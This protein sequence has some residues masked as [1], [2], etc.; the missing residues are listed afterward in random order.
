VKE[1]K[2]LVAEALGPMVAA[3]RKA[4]PTKK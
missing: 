2:Q 1:Q 4:D 3:S